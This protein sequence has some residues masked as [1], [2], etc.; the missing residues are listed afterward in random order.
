MRAT[1]A[2]ETLEL[3]ATKGLSKVESSDVR[4]L[5]EE[6]PF[7][8]SYT[9]LTVFRRE[10]GEAIGQV[11]PTASQLALRAL[12]RASPESEPL[13]TDRAQSLARVYLGEAEHAREKIARRKG[14]K[15]EDVTSLEMIPGLPTGNEKF[16]RGPKKT[17]S[18][19]RRFL[20]LR[21]LY[22]QLIPGVD[23]KAEPAI[24]DQPLDVVTYTSGE[25]DVEEVRRILR[26]QY[27]TGL[28]LTRF[29]SIVIDDHRVIENLS[30]NVK[31]RDYCAE[32]FLFEVNRDFRARFDRYVVGIA[33]G[34]RAH[35]AVMRLVPELRELI[36]L[37]PDTNLDT[38]VE[39]LVSDG[40]LMMRDTSATTGYRSAHFDEVSADDPV[41]VRVETDGLDRKDYRLIE[42]RLD[43][44]NELLHYRSALGMHLR[45]ERRRCT[46]FADGP[47]YVD[48]IQIDV[49]GLEDAATSNNVA[50]VYFLPGTDVALGPHTYEREVHSWIVRHHG[51]TI[52]W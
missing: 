24:V 12:L 18:P 23:S 48:E 25:E 39:E 37:P 11:E 33:A 2:F 26:R 15:G 20:L 13:S 35:R 41:A 46:W 27:G 38:T 43:H 44:P 42:A 30:L 1:G 50:V 31:L 22:D 40:M 17:H 4:P 49:S 36:W 10:I 8:T 9:N 51:F 3:L 52:S 28:E 6:S 19:G 16:R 14:K 45:R 29:A 32:K 7:L 34:D 5:V 21:E 47:T